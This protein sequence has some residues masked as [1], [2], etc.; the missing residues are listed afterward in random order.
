MSKPD[1]LYRFS[2]DQ[3]YL[4]LRVPDDDTEADAVL[5]F[6]RVMA[7]YGFPNPKDTFNERLGVAVFP[8]KVRLKSSRTSRLVT[9]D[10]FKQLEQ[11]F[12]ML[13]ITSKDWYSKRF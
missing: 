10:L 12:R 13:P 4:F 8:V 5:T 1:L 11:H 3:K 6:N 2:L 7:D 9:Y